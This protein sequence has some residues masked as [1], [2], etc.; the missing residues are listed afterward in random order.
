MVECRVS[1]VG[2]LNNF[3]SYEGGGRMRDKQGVCVS[4]TKGTVAHVSRGSLAKS[5]KG[6]GSI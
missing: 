4:F 2:N 6:I 5:E 3:E 1:L